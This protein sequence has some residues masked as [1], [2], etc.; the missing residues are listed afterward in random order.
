LA[1]SDEMLVARCQEGD[2]RAFE[3]LVQKYQR[4]IYHLIHRITQD[5]DVVEPLTQDVFLKAYRSISSFRGASQFYTW[6][7]RIAV[8]TCLSHV[9]REPSHK[10]HEDPQEINPRYFSPEAEA[11]QP[12]NPEQQVMRKEL[13]RQVMSAVRDLPEDFRMTVVLRE[14]MG[15]NYEE[16]AEV[17]EIP[18]G[19]VRSRIFRSRAL[20]RESLRSFR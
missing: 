7:Y 1:S 2:K 8:N 5:P 4:R 3:L 15:L 19:T 20:L 11:L 10:C 12:E 18:L 17:L 16:I 9:K 6:L 13:L 14:F